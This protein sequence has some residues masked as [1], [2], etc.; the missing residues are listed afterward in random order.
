[1]DTKFAVMVVDDA[2]TNLNV[3]KNA[4]DD[5]YDVFT[6]P[7]G[8]KL[9]QI[10]EKVSPDLILLDIEMPEMD[11]YE[12]IKVLKNSKNTE[13]IP[14]IFLT[15]VIDPQS[16]LKGLDMGAI[17]YVTKP[18]S[19]QL[20]LKRI[21]VH[22]FAESQKRNLQ[23]YSSNLEDMVEEKTKMVFELQNAILKTVAELVEHRDSVTGGHIERTQN[24]LKLL[25]DALFKHGVYTEELSTWDV[26]LFI[27]SSQLHDVGKVSIKDSVL[28]KPAKLT[29]EE[30]E[31]MKQHTVYGMNIIR[32]IEKSTKENTFLRHARIMSGS[33]HEKWDGSG[34]PLGLKGENIPLEGRLMAIVDVYDALTNHRPYK[35]QN[36]ER[37]SVRHRVYGSYDAGNGRY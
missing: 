14:V 37:Q 4:L 31:E 17:D 1:M 29:D 21:E 26:G 32:K 6:V 28:M 10:L 22:L 36:R 23:I 18:F 19:K 30:F 11:G 15:S 12:V 27:M 33:H 13:H 24:F 7:S 9:F 34:Y 35:Q 25:V 20:L 8:K 16:E 2:I 5:K 3:A